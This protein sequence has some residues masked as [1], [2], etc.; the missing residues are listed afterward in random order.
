MMFFILEQFQFGCLSAKKKKTSILTKRRKL[1][2][3][4][5]IGELSTSLCWSVRHTNVTLPKQRTYWPTW[6]CYF[7]CTLIKTEREQVHPECYKSHQ[8]GLVLVACTRE[9]TLLCRSVPPSATYFFYN[10]EVEEVVVRRK[11]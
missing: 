9:Y 7:I 10:F 6:P 1:Q 11:W 5:K 3:L 4:L 2:M 8:Q